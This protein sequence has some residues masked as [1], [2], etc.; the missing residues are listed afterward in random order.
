MS[1]PNASVYV[2]PATGR[3]SKGH[4]STLGAVSGRTRGSV[5]RRESEDPGLI[6]SPCSSA[7]AGTISWLSSVDR[8]RR[9]LTS[10]Y[11]PKAEYGI[12]SSG[13]AKLW[14]GPR[15]GA[16]RSHAI[17]GVVA[18]RRSPG[19]CNAMHRIAPWFRRLFLAIRSFDEPPSGGCR[20]FRFSS[21]RRASVRR[22]RKR[23]WR[24]CHCLAVLHMRLP[25]EPR[26]HSWLNDRS[27]GA[28]PAG[29]PIAVGASFSKRR[30][31]L[32]APRLLAQTG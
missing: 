17:G 5:R 18:R 27:D 23:I 12:V 9:R 22:R 19:P 14:L 7:N 21:G 1:L 30:L 3:R 20:R 4:N 16:G 26:Q 24:L 2:R 10:Q 15:P 32:A 6:E 25:V 8:L 29:F 11:H 31:H 28:M 13:A